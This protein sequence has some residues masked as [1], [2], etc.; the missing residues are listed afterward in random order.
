[1][2]FADPLS[3]LSL[4]QYASLCAEL[5]VFPEGAEGIFRRYGLDSDE[6]RAAVDAAWKER[7]RNDP[8]VYE[9]WQELYRRYHAHWAKQGTAPQS[10]R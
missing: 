4:A 2:F 5:T 7:L 3:L 9:A 8:E 1:M 10:S 6:K